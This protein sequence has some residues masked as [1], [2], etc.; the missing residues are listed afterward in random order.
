MSRRACST[1]PRPAYARLLAGLAER[2]PALPPTPA[3]D[4]AD[5]AGTPAV[6][7][8]RGEPVPDEP[9]HRQAPVAPE[10]GPTPT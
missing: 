9:G 1:E 4:T 5:T 7:P 3:A 6:L 8:D 10:S 2:Y